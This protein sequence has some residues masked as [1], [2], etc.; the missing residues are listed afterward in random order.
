MFCP[1]CGSNQSDTL[2]YCKS[3]GANLQAVRQA[4]TTG[5]PSNDSITLGQTWIAD[6]FLSGPERR[7]RQEEF[8]RRR[9]I[10]L[11]H[12]GACNIKNGTIT[13]AAGL[14]GMLVVFFLMQGLV[15]NATLTPGMAAILSRVWLI[16]L[17]PFLVGIAYIIN[18]F[19]SKRWLA[20]PLLKAGSDATTGPIG[21]ADYANR[22]LVSPPDSVT[23]ATTRNLE[24]SRANR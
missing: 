7:A 8:E 12:K 10:T 21:G 18:G 3:C 23:E 11:E 4:L 9:G 17:I 13:A 19:G 24:E 2:N 16:G 15:A 20:N 6:I 1:Q 22:A 5:L 14:G